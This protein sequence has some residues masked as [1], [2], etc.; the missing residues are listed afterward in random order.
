MKLLQRPW[1]RLR[2]Y[3]GKAIQFVE[4]AHRTKPNK[5]IK[6]NLFLELP[7]STNCHVQLVITN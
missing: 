2:L 4:T 6:L 5:M 7:S 1:K 3:S